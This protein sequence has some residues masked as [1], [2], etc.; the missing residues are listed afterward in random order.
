MSRS[1]LILA[2]LILVA[3]G[4]GAAF[5]LRDRLASMRAPA[6]EQG[7]APQDLMPTTGLYG[8]ADVGTTLNWVQVLPP[9]HRRLFF[10]L[11]LPRDWEWRQPPVTAEEWAG[12]SKLPVTLL[13]AGPRSN[14]DAFLEV[15]YLKV[16]QE[17][18]VERFV[19][20]FADLSGHEV[21][22]DEP[23]AVGAQREKVQDALLRK[24]SPEFGPTLTRMLATRR[25]EYVFVVA[26]SAPQAS[27]R[28]WVRT[29]G[30]ALT[31]FNPSGK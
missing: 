21:V 7:S 28:K 29:F 18:S 5:L 17:V 2:L 23:K 1:A 10:Q 26:G 14:E 6:A 22:Y 25:G 3:A 30:A 4:A 8:A 9:G 19:R 12:D 15:R 11:L 24:R 16:P 27:F 31:S 13:Q 20:V